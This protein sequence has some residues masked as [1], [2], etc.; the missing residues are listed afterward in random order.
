MSELSYPP[1]YYINLEHRTDRKIHILAQ[2]HEMNYPQ[3]RIHRIDAVKHEFGGL[4][5]C[6]SHIKALQTFV[7]TQEERCI[8]LEDDFTFYPNSYDFFHNIIKKENL[9]L[10]WDVIMLSSNTITELPYSNTFTKCIDA[11]TTSGYM[12]NRDFINILLQNFKESEYLLSQTLQNGYHV[13]AID[14]YWKKIQPH[15]NWY[16]CKPKLGYQ[17]ESYSDVENKVV[18][19]KT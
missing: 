16:I 12:V 14:Q 8:I 7:S 15:S 19:Y 9:P 1:I 6:R 3:D 13:F 18:D 4:G 5:C 11:Q 2:L 10:T 17:L